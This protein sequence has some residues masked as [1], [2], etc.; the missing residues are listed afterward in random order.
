[1]P[2][3]EQI[4]KQKQATRDALIPK[5]WRLRSLPQED[6]LNVTKIPQSAGILSDHEISITENYDATSLSE[7][8][9]ARTL[10]SHEVTLAYCK[11]AAIAQQ[12]TNCLTEIFFEKALARAKA[13]DHHLQRYGTPQGPL[14]GV[15]I[16]LKDTFRVTGVDSTIGYAA[17]ANQPS[18]FNSPLVNILLEAGAVLYCK[19][20]VPQT[21]MA[22]DSENNVWGRTLNPIN[23]KVTAGGSSGGEGALLAM[24]GSVLGIGTDIG[25]SIRIPA[26]CN[27][28]YGIK[29]SADRVPYQGQQEP[30][31]PGG[32]AISMKSRAGPMARSLRDCE[33]LLS[34]VANAKPWLRDPNIVP[35]LWESMDLS[36][37]ALGHSQP[38]K[39]LTFGVLMTDNVMT[40]LPPVRNVMREMKS[41]LEKAGHTAVVIPT[42]PSFSKLLSLS[43]AVLSITGSQHSFSILKRTGEPLSTWLAPRISEKGPRGVLEAADI[44]AQREQI[45]TQLLKELWSLSTPQ[46][47][48]EVDALICPVAP[49]PVPGLDKW[50]GVSYTIDWVLLDYCAGFLPVRSFTENDMQAEFE[51]AE[52]EVLGRWDKYNRTLW[53]K[54]DRSIYLGTP[55]GVQVV[56]P[57]LQERR[58]YRAMDAADRA[59]RGKEWAPD[60]DKNIS[61]A[62]GGMAGAKL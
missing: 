30:G 58:L 7:A 45:S 60:V 53:E 14:H 13:L 17:F 33:L 50:G 54:E 18:L 31:I 44:Q 8:I 48:Q 51:G 16:S 27:G 19:T 52:K 56:A 55:L 9:R 38:N 15:P 62:M 12:L 20:N 42:P 28:L 3:Y 39:G 59:V 21:L 43:N 23:R 6:V 35:G 37:R 10:T 22:L 26:F 29:P 40:P 47:S 1:M 24:K 41:T 4:A 49:H 36:K 2:K 25:G 11:R 46:G 34:T 32:A 61:D 5:E 57:R